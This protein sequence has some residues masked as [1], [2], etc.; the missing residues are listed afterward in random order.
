METLTRTKTKEQQYNEYLAFGGGMSIEEWE[1]DGRYDRWLSG[2]LPEL[3]QIP[4]VMI[5]ESGE[6]YLQKEDLLK[7]LQ[8]LRQRYKKDTETLL[9]ASILLK[10]KE[11]EIAEANDELQR[12]RDENIQYSLAI[13][14]T[15]DHAR[16][17]SL[18]ASCLNDMVRAWLILF[19]KKWIIEKA[20]SNVRT[21]KEY[22]KQAT[23]MRDHYSRFNHYIKE[24]QAW[25]DGDN[26]PY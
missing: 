23:H 3:V 17:R 21:A 1:A 19:E 16:A 13:Q 20:A 22:V 14:T 15:G 8:E 26:L 10:E 4:S 6:Q 11:G 18:E 7:E 5:T 24:V 9:K 25:I 12:L 2:E